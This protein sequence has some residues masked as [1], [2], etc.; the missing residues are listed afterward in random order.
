MP[1]IPS[2]PI[3]GSYLVDKKVTI[4]SALDL[5]NVDNTSDAN[6]PVSTAQSTALAPKA[7]PTFTGTATFAA[8]TITG[9]LT[10]K[11]GITANLPLKTGT[12]GAIEAGAWGTASG[13]FCQGNDSRL[14]LNVKSDTTQAGTGSVAIANMVTI[15][16]AD[17]NI[18]AGISPAGADNT[19]ATTLYIIVE[20]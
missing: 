7:S 13:T 17:Y 8:V 2:V 4:K 20:P 9:V 1:T 19:D 14:L 6:K 10:A 16:E 3:T 5:G 12:A 11:I 18:L 15:T